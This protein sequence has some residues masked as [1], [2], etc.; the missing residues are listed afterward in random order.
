MSKQVDEKPDL[1]RIIFDT[2]FERVVLTKTM[3]HRPTFVAERISEDAMGT[4][5]WVKVGGTAEVDILNRALL[6]AYKK[7][8]GVGLD[9]LILDD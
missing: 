9:D 8:D 4:K 7:Y 3:Y 2:G 5:V 6:H 1:P